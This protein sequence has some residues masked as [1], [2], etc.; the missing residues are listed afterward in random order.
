MWIYYSNISGMQIYIYGHI[1][2]YYVNA[3]HNIYLYTYKPT[4]KIKKFNFHIN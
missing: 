1:I 2:L 4:M 3:Y